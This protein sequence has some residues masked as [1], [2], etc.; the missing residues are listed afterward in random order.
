VS[1]GQNEGVT[2]EINASITLTPGVITV[3]FRATDVATG[4]V[5][6]ASVPFA[7]S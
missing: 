4:K 2:I 7:K 6:S 3:K 1:R 5:I